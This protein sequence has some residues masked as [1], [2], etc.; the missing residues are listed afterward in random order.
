MPNNTS[1]KLSKASCHCGAVSLELAE[2]PVEIFECSC[3]ICRRLGVFWAYYH[4]DNVAIEII[5]E[6][7][8]TYVWNNEVLEF[9]RCSNCGCTTHWIAIDP[10]FRERMGV[11]AR[12]ID[13]LNRKNTKIGYVDHGKLGWFWSQDSS[14]SL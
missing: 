9:H 14:S 7:T 5:E 2:K 6:P 4:C 10:N 1:A 8:N 12:L 11:N 3:S 13:G